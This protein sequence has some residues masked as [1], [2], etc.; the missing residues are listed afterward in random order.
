MQ[1]RMK[2]ERALHETHLRILLYSGAYPPS[3]GGVET[4]AVTLA[5]QLVQL[6]HDCI[7]VTETPDNAQYDARYQNQFPVYRRPSKF[8]RL[9]LARWCSLIHSNGASVAMYPYAV[10]TGRPFMW[11][12][13]GYQIQCVDGLGWVGDHHTPMT[14]LASLRHTLRSAGIVRAA[15]E[16]LK[17]AIRRFVTHRVAINVA[18]TKWVAGRLNAPR[19]TVGYTPY[20]LSR[21]RIPGMLKD[22]PYDFIFV[23]RFVNEKGILDLINAFARLKEDTR[24]KDSKLAL[25]G[26]GPIRNDIELRIQELSLNA[27]VDLLGRKNGS[28]LVEAMRLGRVG[29]VPSRWEEPM[30]G[31]ALELL[32]SGRRL[33]VSASGG[34]AEC[35][36]EVALTF[37]NG[38]SEALCRCMAQAITDPEFERNHLLKA[39]EVISKFD[40]RALTEGYIQLYRAVVNGLATIRR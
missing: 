4:I 27:S 5:T 9:K 6:G 23:G 15:A 1:S 8:Q 29:I 30:G 18:C 11:T 36:E 2:L 33:I 22:V 10:L 3:L 40:E 25:V 20:D 31:V 17:M 24:F 28:E 16:S 12:H 21:F 37:P 26:D 32:A 34:I 14:P 38:D 19:M 39:P 7:V 35:V 13:N